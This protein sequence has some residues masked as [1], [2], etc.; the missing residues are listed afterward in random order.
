MRRENCLYNGGGD[1]FPLASVPRNVPVMNRLDLRSAAGRRNVMVAV[2]LGT[3][4]TTL[5]P[6]RATAAAVPADEPSPQTLTDLSRYCTACWKNARLPAD[7]WTDC[8]QEVFARLLE[9]LPRDR[10]AVVLGSEGEERRE[11]LRA[12]DAVKKRTQ[13]SRK[14]A[15]LAAD[16][17]D[18]RP[19]PAGPYAE[20]REVLDQAAGRV[21]SP[22]QR[23][24][25]QLSRDGWSIPE[26]ASELRT[27]PERVSDEKYKA[28]RKLRAHLL[29]AAAVA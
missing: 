19:T 10:W 7:H 28:I 15:G 21:L 9:R 20:E 1:K 27:S 29:P 16:P 8:T 5:A 24:I 17:A 23:R 3:A 13:R 18:P 25:V 6:S 22:R 14:V 2:M 12:I 26:I 4:L 11:F